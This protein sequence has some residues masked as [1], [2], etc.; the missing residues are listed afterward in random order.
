MKILRVSIRG[1]SIFSVF[2]AAWQAE[3]GE[4]ESLRLVASDDDDDDAQVAR[5]TQRCLRDA[6][7]CIGSAC[8]FVHK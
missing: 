6:R 5:E 1:F 4:S 7:L 3:D 8:Q 2:H